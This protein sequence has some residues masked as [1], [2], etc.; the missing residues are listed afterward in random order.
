MKNG[1][2]NF[3]KIELIGPLYIANRVRPSPSLFSQKFLFN[4]LVSN[5]SLN[6]SL[7]CQLKLDYYIMSKID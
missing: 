5:L 6:T 4:N 1:R 3:E 7:I 2:N